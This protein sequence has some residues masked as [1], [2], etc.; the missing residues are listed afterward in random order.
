M[1]NTVYETVIGLEV[2]VQLATNSKAFCADDASFGGEPNT[3]VSA[4]SLGHPGTLPKA[5]RRQI[6]L[7]TRLGL[8]LGCRINTTKHVVGCTWFF[9]AGSLWYSIIR[10][11]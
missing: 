10:R 8:A 4:V 7:A 5:N 1:E 9:T 11:S 3:Q 2:H 6:E